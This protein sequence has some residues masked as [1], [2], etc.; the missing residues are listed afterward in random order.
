MT[1]LEYLT[2]LI[3]II[4]GLGLADLLESAYRLT[5]A[6]SRIRFHWLP[7]SWG[8]MVFII[9]IIFFWTFFRVGQLALWQNMFAFIFMLVAPI[10][11]F[12]ASANALPDEVPPEGVLDLEHFYFDRP[13]GFFLLLAGYM[14]HTVV[15]DLLRGG[16]IW[17]GEQLFRGGAFLLMLLLAGSRNRWVHRTGTLVAFML[18]IGFIVRYALQIN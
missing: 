12:L 5:K 18:I 9:V 10:L 14:L 17:S 1:Q 6:R 15:V 8:F 4:I 2:T 3:S 13:R 16:S 11:L 7:L